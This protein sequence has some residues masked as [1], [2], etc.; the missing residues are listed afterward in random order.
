MTL[1]RMGVL[2]S[3]P[4]DFTSV[5]ATELGSAAKLAPEFAKRNVKLI[6]LPIDCVEDHPAWSKDIN[7]YNC[8]EPRESDL[9]PSW[10]SGIGTSLSCWAC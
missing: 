10:M 6:A 3:Q 7:A 4:R 8:E 9:F 2:F 1:G 5:C